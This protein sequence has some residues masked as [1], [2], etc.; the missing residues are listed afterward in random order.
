MTGK[1]VLLQKLLL[2]HRTTIHI[3]AIE[4]SFLLSTTLKGCYSKF[5]NLKARRFY[6]RCP[7]TDKNTVYCYLTA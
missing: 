7:K 5:V 6:E 2:K 1:N 4:R 3:P